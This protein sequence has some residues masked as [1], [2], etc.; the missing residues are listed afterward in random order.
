M[1]FFKKF[2]IN[3][4]FFSGVLTI[5][6]ATIIA[7]IIT[8]LAA[9]FITKFYEVED[10]G[11]LSIFA[12]A[13]ALLSPISSFRLEAAICIPKNNKLAANIVASSI[14]ILLIY[15]VAISSIL[16]LF[17]DKLFKQLNVLEL[18]DYIWLIPISVFL[19]GIYRIFNY[20]AIRKKQDVK[21]GKTR[22]LRAASL[23]LTQIVLNSLNALGLIIGH[24]VGQSVGFVSLAKGFKLSDINLKLII[25]GYKKYYKQSFISSI[26]LYMNVITQ[27]LPLLLIG[28][29]FGLE[30]AAYYFFVNKL[31]KSPMTMFGRTINDLILRE[32]VE[33]SSTFSKLIFKSYEKISLFVMPVCLFIFIHGPLLF[34]F[35]LDEDWKTSGIMASYLMPMMY[36]QIITQPFSNTFYMLKKSLIL[37]IWQMILLCTICL[38]L[39]MGSLQNDIIETIIY[40]SISGFLMYILLAFITFKMLK[41][42]L[43]KIAKVQVKTAMLAIALNVPFLILL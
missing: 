26:G 37:T 43:M 35:I 36:M 41:L 22:I 11:L 33:K 39:Y 1:P 13:I 29:I 38:S 27:Q 40:L 15:T 2:K 32:D 12:A 42:N 7:Q 8:I 20:W 23:M 21:I 28:V 9:I 18:I 5:S 16:I 25:E 30:S 6:F 19:S 31:I 17:A 10:I 4:D 14:G 34:E 3:N 24:I